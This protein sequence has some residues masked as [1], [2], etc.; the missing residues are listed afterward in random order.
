MG[1]KNYITQP[2]I[3]KYFII[4]KG[5]LDCSMTQAF[6]DFII[7]LMSE[8]TVVEDSSPGMVFMFIVSSMS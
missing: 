1:L 8:Q 2:F 6:P 4:T 5:L 3:S 7:F